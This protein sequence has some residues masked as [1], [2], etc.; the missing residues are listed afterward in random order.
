VRERL[1][2]GYDVGAG[3]EHGRDW[4]VAIL[5]ASA[6]RAHETKLHDT[7]ERTC[8]EAAKGFTTDELDRARKKVR[9]RFA[10]LATRAW[11][12]P[13]R[14]LRAPRARIRRWPPRRV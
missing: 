11:I 12:A 8:R 3:L 7:V 5:S 9:Y 4:A 1:G 6:A 13:C 2:L 10:R 14:T